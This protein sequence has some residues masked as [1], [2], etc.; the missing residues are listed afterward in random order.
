[1]HIITLLCSSCIYQTINLEYYMNILHKCLSRFLKFAH[2]DTDKQSNQNM[3]L[4]RMLE[5]T[6][7]RPLNINIETTTI[8]NSRCCFC[9]YP[10]A[11]RKTEMMPEQLFDKIIDEYGSLGG[12]PIGFSPLM[13]DP[14][15]D[16]HLPRRIKK[17]QDSSHNFW[18][19][20]FTN[21]IGFSNFSLEDLHTICSIQYINISMGGPDRENYLRMYKVD[22]FDRVVQ[23]IR[24]INEL[25][26][27][28]NKNLKISIH[29][30]CIDPDAIRL[31]DIYKEFLDYGF[32]CNDIT[33]SFTTFGGSVLQSDVPDGV[34]ICD[35]DNSTIKVDCA[36]PYTE[37]TICPN[38]DVIMCGCFDFNNT[39]LAGN[40]NT[41]TL[42]EIWKSNTYNKF[43]T[44]FSRND[45]PPICL[46]CANYVHRDQ[47]LG[48]K[49]LA[50]YDPH[51]ETFW[52]FLQ[53]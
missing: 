20:M 29:F 11:N 4:N 28:I 40:I 37:Y 19:H 48:N 44:A 34:K 27:R 16:P 22:Q 24:K 42:I 45:I 25:K 15:M 21:A 6:N 33:N 50:N 46:S 39:T 10:K 1:M 52:S 2:Q 26:N 7:K 17:M 30:R 49:G 14:L 31:S 36:I 51:G 3:V 18:I 9:G 12:G 38:G 35:A 13:S 5:I 43:R 53:Y 41:H 47:I 8:C 23:N 32:T